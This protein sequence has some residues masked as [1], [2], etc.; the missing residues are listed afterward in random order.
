VLTLFALALIDGVNPSA[1]VVTIVLGK[2]MNAKCAGGLFAWSATEL[3][4][5]RVR[6]K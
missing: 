5:I 1:I 2:R 4:A 3:A 6:S